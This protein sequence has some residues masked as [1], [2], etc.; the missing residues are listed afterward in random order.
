MSC[1]CV[2][3]TMSLSFSQRTPCLGGVGS[4]RVGEER[5]VHRGRTRV[6]VGDR[7]CPNQWWEF[8]HHCKTVELMVETDTRRL[9]A[10]VG[11]RER[12][13]VRSHATHD[14]KMNDTECPNAGAV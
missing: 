13:K 1:R 6:G 14:P 10:L 7:C 12:H 8:H 2:V 4:W 3:S 9:G 5:V 11:R